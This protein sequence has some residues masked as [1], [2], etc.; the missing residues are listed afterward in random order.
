M[1][2]GPQAPNHRDHQPQRRPAGDG[3]AERLQHHDPRAQHR[4]RGA[5]HGGSGG[6]TK[7]KSEKTSSKF[8]GNRDFAVALCL[9]TPSRL[10]VIT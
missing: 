5:A 8:A 6:D 1:W 7:F 4:D 10:S 9:G 2:T 3:N